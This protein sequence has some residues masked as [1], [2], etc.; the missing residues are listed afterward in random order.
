MS[1]VK[2]AIRGAN[3]P[4]NIVVRITKSREEDFR[5]VTGLSVPRVAW[6]DKRNWFKSNARFSNSKEVESHL[7]GLEAFLYEEM[8]NSSSDGEKLS[9][10]WLK[11]RIDRFNNQDATHEEDGLIEYM[12]YLI[13]TLPSR[14]G[15]NGKVGIKHITIKKYTT[16]RNKISDF[17]KY[18]KKKYLL[19]DVDLVFR[20]DFV[21][22]L[23]NEQ[24]LNENTIGR[25]LS[26]VRSACRKAMEDGKKVDKCIAQGLFTSLSRKTSFVILSESEIK[27][28]FEY[29]FQIGSYL[30]NARDWLVISTWTAAR[31][32]DL[33]NLN[34]DNIIEDGENL[35]LE[36]V[37]SK[38]E[39]KV[40]IP[41]H[42][43][44]KSILKK[45]DWSFPRPIS[46]TN[47]NKYIKMVCREVGLDELVE[48]E[49]KDP[50]TNR[51]ISGR[52]P[53]YELVTSHIGRRSFA[54]NLYGKMPTVYIMSATGHLTEKSFLKYIDKKSVD[55]KE[56]FL[57]VW[58]S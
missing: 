11:Q 33:L 16:V 23:K 9:S 32:G 38:T 3:D 56:A 6:S 46:M 52:F 31:A 49:R 47:Y 48:G 22:F 55:N 40:T 28:I 17:E 19:R 27:Q 35:I 42:E 25:C 58:G 41:I 36:Y 54:T 10:G 8:N 5:R 26:N 53:K 44:V 50:K 21:S 13:E 37:S 30:D 29:P 57:K 1:T 24:G 2:F 51:K 15:S 20:K 43:Q 45:Y 39:N 4:A 34:N 18:T 14:V 7:R 12:D